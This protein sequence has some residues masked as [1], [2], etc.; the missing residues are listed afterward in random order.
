[1]F[2]AGATFI[3]NGKEINEEGLSKSLALEKILK[4]LDVTK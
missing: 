4:K 2:I 1:M 3:Q